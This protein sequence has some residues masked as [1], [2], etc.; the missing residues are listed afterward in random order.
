M[1]EE[2]RAQWHSGMHYAA[3]NQALNQKITF[4]AGAPAL[5]IMQH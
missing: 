3:K 5:G 2:N 1:G 4:C